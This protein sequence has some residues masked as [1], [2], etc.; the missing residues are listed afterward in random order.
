[1]QTRVSKRGEAL[2]VLVTSLSLT[3]LNSI[4]IPRVPTFIRPTSQ[5]VLDLIFTNDSSSADSVSLR[6][7]PELSSDHLPVTVLLR[8]DSSSNSDARALKRSAADERTHWNYEKADW[9]CFR[10]CLSLLLHPACF[11]DRFSDV[12]PGVA[13]RSDAAQRLVDSMA[14]ALESALLSA[15]YCAIPRKV[16]RPSNHHWHQHAGVRVAISHKNR[17][18]RFYRK[19]PSLTH[20]HQAYL[21]AKKAAED[22][23]KR[24]KQES[25][26][27]LLRKLE[28]PHLHGKLLWSI[29]RRS[30]AEKSQ[31]ASASL[32]S[33]QDA[34]GN[35]PSSP[36][37]SLNNLASHFAQAG[38]HPRPFHE[39]PV[40]TRILTDASRHIEAARDPPPILSVEDI[41]MLCQR[42]SCSTSSGPDEIAP[43]FIRHGGDALAKALTLVFNFSLSHSVV[44]QSWRLA[45]VICL[46][47]GAG[48]DA[49]SPSSYRPIS[50]TSTLIR[51]FERA[52]YPFIW[53]RFEPSIHPQQ[54][55]FRAHHNTLDNLFAVTQLIQRA[56]R[57]QHA[58]RSV[59]RSLP[60]AFLDLVKAFDRVNHRILL[61]RLWQ[62]GIRGKLW[63]WI[64]AFLTGRQFQ[65]RYAGRLSALFPLDAGVPQGSVLAPLLFA[66]FINSLPESIQAHAVQV[67]VSL[68]ADDVAIAPLVAGSEG[69]RALQTAL[70]IAAAWADSNGMEFSPAKSAV[71]LFSSQRDSCDDVAAIRAYNAH[72]PVEVRG[73]EVPRK[74]QTLL[75]SASETL[76][77]QAPIANR[78]L[79][80]SPGR[81]RLRQSLPAV[82]Y[83]LT[84]SP[85]R[86]PSDGAISRSPSLGKSPT[87]SLSASSSPAR[88]QGSVNAR[89]AIPCSPTS[90]RAEFPSDSTAVSH[91]SPSWLAQ[92]PSFRLS[93]FRLQL[94]SSY[95]Y[96]GLILQNDG[97]WEAQTARVMQTA[98]LACNA[99]LRLLPG[100][101]P[102]ARL[103]SI[104][105]HFSSIRSL[106]LT[107]LLPKVSYALC[108]WRP[109]D[110]T[111]DLLD[112]FM[113]QPLRRALQLPH[114][115]NRKAMRAE[116]CVP[117]MRHV[118]ESQLLK[119]AVH[120]HSL[121]AEDPT[122]RALHADYAQSY[123]I[124]MHQPEYA[125]SFAVE[126]RQV[127]QAWETTFTTIANSQQLHKISRDKMWRETEAD[128]DASDTLQHF[129]TLKTSFQ[130][131]AYLYTDPP[132]I[133]SIRASFRLNCARTHC[134]LHSR[135]QSDSSY[136]PYCSRAPARAL[137]PETIPH[138]LL[139]CP[140]H[141][142][143]R[144][145]VRKDI[146]TEMRKSGEKGASLPHLTLHHLLGADRISA[147]NPG[148]WRKPSPRLLA[149]LLHHSAPLMQQLYLI[150][151]ARYR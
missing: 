116:F 85:R 42:Q 108:M 35:P 20:A 51:L 111:L 125:R 43:H 37:H 2:A 129:L 92:L 105:P 126:L 133:A 97:K 22:A 58:R 74:H 50:L 14:S 69:H 140:Q 98:Q 151:K 3:C 13:A 7:Y 45:H 10:A 110:A 5:E 144:E 150:M 25:L 16:L 84:H 122:H 15:A 100:P 78:P 41:T 115:I 118:R 79:P 141:A 55:G 39:P 68:F 137:I 60:I 107:Y 81:F 146:E 36:Q 57:E 130:R 109:G 99:I 132:N 114:H 86:S 128:K 145:K 96:V 9:E 66:I 103:S 65:V 11:Q 38:K 72:P 40:I 24:A 120:A 28:T 33:I 61:A 34:Q 93:T 67:L 104:S 91:V 94:R 106:T 6:L 119:F 63:C 88:R 87:R 127:E 138:M 90:K 4:H 123:S 77:G 59:N 95:R 75:R 124:G 53:R 112:G 82:N 29:F 54:H 62:Y 8:S 17:A 113:L 18:Q 89:P 46:S 131:S 134:F 56:L 80:P 21:R 83:S 30:S 1:M 70:H 71:V 19:N 101:A 26:Q 76:K 48:L 142:P 136:C 121:P 47:K 27:D 117:S 139:D 73:V 147:D 31:A 135:H 149:A 23:I 102:S 49:A 12:I 52:L 148:E 32:H 44:P 64:R 143:T